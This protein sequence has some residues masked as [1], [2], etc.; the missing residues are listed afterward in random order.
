MTRILLSLQIYCT[1]PLLLPLE[2]FFLNL[3]KSPWIQLKAI[4]AC[5]THGVQLILSVQKPAEDCCCF[6]GF[7][8]WLC[9]QTIA[10]P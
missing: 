2:S 8:A 3:I 9:D 10:V 7:F 6:R 1:L 4:L 5:L